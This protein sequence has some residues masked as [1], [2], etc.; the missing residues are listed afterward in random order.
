[1][2]KQLCR[3]DGGMRCI[4]MSDG[5][6]EDVR[7]A[8]HAESEAMTVA[9]THLMRFT[10]FSMLPESVALRTVEYH[11]KILR[12][13]GFTRKEATAL[14][15]SD[16]A[17]ITQGLRGS[18]IS[19]PWLGSVRFAALILVAMLIGIEATQEMPGLWECLRRRD[20]EGAADALMMS[21]WLRMVGNEDEE[22]RRAMDILR[23][24]RIGV[25]APATR[26][27]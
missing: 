20:Y 15:G 25:L 11:T 23:M 1:M 2:A 12:D 22:K 3:G 14:L 24:L 17:K 27:H 9:E 6:D 19:M 5:H 13:Q 18:T 26:T 16:M 21:T 8:L 10:P 4:G 7:S